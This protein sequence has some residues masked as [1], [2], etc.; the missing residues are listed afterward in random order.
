MERYMRFDTQFLHQRDKTYKE[1]K[2]ISHESVTSFR[3]EEWFDSLLLDMEDNVTQVLGGVG[4]S[5][6]VDMKYVTKR[7]EMVP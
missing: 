3:R 4:E 7:R 2:D 6:C 1:F 5:T